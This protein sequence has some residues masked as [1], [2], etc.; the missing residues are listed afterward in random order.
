LGE[1]EPTACVCRRLTTEALLL[2]GGLN[3]DSWKHAAALVLDLTG[4]RSDLCRLGDEGSD[5]DSEAENQEGESKSRDFPHSLL[6]LFPCAYGKPYA[7]DRTWRND[8]SY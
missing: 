1:Q 4:E 8:L 3:A 2:V 7:T 6:L 5:A